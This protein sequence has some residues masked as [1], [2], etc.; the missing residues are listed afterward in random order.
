MAVRAWYRPKKVSAFL[1]QRRVPGIDVLAG[2]F[3]RGQPASGI[4]KFMLPLISKIGKHDAV[5]ESVEG[6]VLLASLQDVR[7]KQ[8]LFGKSG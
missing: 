2:V 6:E 8:L 4:S 1:E 7:L 3:L 5:L